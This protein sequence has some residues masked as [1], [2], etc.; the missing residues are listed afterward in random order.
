VKRLLTIM[1]AVGLIIGGAG[2]ASGQDFLGGYHHKFIA[3]IDF[4]DVGASAVAAVGAGGVE[5]EKEVTR[6]DGG[7]TKT[8]SLKV[9]GPSGSMVEVTIWHDAT[10]AA[11][12]SLRTGDLRQ[13][14][15]FYAMGSGYVSEAVTSGSFIVRRAHISL[16]PEDEGR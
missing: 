9:R 1:L 13:E 10:V 11:R 4:A 7:M 5:Y 14:R 6:H 15:S 12:S 16:S 8:S 2:F 3:E